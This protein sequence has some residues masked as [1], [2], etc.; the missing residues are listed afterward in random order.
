M[1]PTLPSGPDPSLTAA[2]VSLSSHHLFTLSSSEL[3]PVPTNDVPKYPEGWSSLIGIITAIVGNILISFALNTQRYAHIRLA[4]EAAEEDALARRRKREPNSNDESRNGGG[5]NKS[6]KRKAGHSALDGHDSGR[7]EEE[8]D[9]ASETD[10]LLPLSASQSSLKR[11]EHDAAQRKSYLHSPYWWIGIVL[12]TVGEAGNFLAYGF[13]PAS[14][15]SPLG[16]VALISN[17]MIAPFMLKESFRARDLLGVLISVGGA[18][19]VVLSAKSDNPKLGP[20]QIWYLITRWEFETYLGISVG[21]I[22]A[23]M[24]ASRKYGQN[25]IFIDLG[26][27][28]LFGLCTFDKTR[29]GTNADLDYRWIYCSFDQ[30]RRISIILQALACAHLPRHL[31]ARFH[32][33]LHCHHADKIRQS[34]SATLRFYPSHPYTICHVHA[35]R[36]PRQRD[37]IPRLRE[38]ARRRGWEICWRLCTDLPGRISDHQCPRARR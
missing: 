34:C 25:S 22:I 8:Q 30:G 32:P 1:P 28:G 12:M 29:N 37:P 35:F 31:P 5:A 11:R 36:H 6:G 19:T 23:L 38:D 15:V 26:L 9:E 27:V 4:Q 16:V 17:C 2:I 21:C 3:A 33:R 14:I 7:E 20:D 10:V 13:A 24:W 18:V